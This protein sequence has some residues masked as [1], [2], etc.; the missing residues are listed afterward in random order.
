MTRILNIERPGSRLRIYADAQTNRIV[1]LANE[2][3][4]SKGNWFTVSR[5]KLSYR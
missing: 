5:L 1:L 3:K 4:D 2:N